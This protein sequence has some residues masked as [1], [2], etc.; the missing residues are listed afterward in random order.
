[1]AT[2]VTCGAPNP[3]SVR[4]PRRKFCSVVCKNAHHNAKQDHHL[5][6]YGIPRAEVLRMAAEQGGCAVCGAASADWVVDHDHRCCPGKKTCGRCVRGVLCRVCNGGLGMFADN[7]DLLLAASLYLLR[8]EDVL[9]AK[10][11][12]AIS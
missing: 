1:M 10:P 12:L 3:A 8:G 2:C 9:T 6:L 11:T 4:G 5:R 7:P